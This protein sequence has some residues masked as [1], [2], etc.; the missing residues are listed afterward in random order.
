MFLLKRIHMKVQGCLFGE[1]TTSLNMIH[2]TIGLMRGVVR[3]VV[4]GKDYEG[5]KVFHR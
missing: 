5:L 3:I 1:G 4:W 2:Q